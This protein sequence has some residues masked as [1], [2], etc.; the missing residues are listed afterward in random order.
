MARWCF[1]SSFAFNYTTKIAL[2]QDYKNILCVTKC[3]GMFAVAPSA[4]VRAV[5]YFFNFIN[6]TRGASAFP[7]KNSI[8]SSRF[9]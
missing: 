6:L 2:S 7:R 4:S 8:S 5:A 9:C 3:G 1:Y